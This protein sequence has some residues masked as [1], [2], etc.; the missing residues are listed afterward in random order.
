VVAIVKPPPCQAHRPVKC[1]LER[2]HDCGNATSVTRRSSSWQAGRVTQITIPIYLET[3]KKRVFASAINWPGWCRTARSPELAIEALADYAARYRPVA[4]RAGLTLPTGEFVVVD[5]VIGTS[6]TDFG[7]PDRPTASDGEPVSV[8][9]ARRLADLVLA[10]W[11]L[12]DDVVAA[13]PAELRKGP[14][15]GGRD[16]DAMYQH[17]VAAEAAYARKLGVRSATPEPGDAAAVRAMREAEVEVLG[18]PGSSDSSW[19]RPY[20]ARRIAWHALDHAWEIED[21]STTDR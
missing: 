3:G 15:G 20:A 17:V 21:R 5:E 4:V 1:L 2:T 9:T 12:L 7:A 8:E 11:Q 14:R 16:T 6:T 18:V 13:A 19:S 10:S